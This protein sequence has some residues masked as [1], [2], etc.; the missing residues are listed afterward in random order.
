MT[1]EWKK[2]N[3][4]VVLMMVA[5]TIMS[6]IPQLKKIKRRALSPTYMSNQEKKGK[7]KTRNE[8]TSKVEAQTRDV[9]ERACPDVTHTHEPGT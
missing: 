7:K 1:G 3:G 9:M 2:W 5:V 4:S 6:D 8:T